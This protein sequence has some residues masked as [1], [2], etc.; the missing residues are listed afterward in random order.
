MAAHQ[1]S[2]RSSSARPSSTRLL[3]ACLAVSP[4]LIALTPAVAFA[5]DSQQAVSVDV[6][7][8]KYNFIGEIDGNNV[9]VRSGPADSHYPVAKL[10]RGTRVKVVGIRGNYLKIEPPDGTF[11][12]VGKAYVER[13]GD[14]TQGKVNTT[15]NVRAGSDINA[16][17]TY[18]QTKLEPGMDVKIQGEQDEYYKIDPPAGA[19]VYIHEQYVRPVQV[20]GDN[21]A[22]AQP[23]Q[24]RPQ[25]PGVATAPQPQQDRNPGQPPVEAAQGGVADRGAVEQPALPD[26][27]PSTQ[28]DTAPSARAGTEVDGKF[29]Q[30]EAQFEA[31]AEKPVIEQPL[32]ELLAGYSTLSKEGDLPESLKRV[33]DARLAAIKV[34]QEAREQFRQALRSQGEMRERTQALQAERE[35][36]EQRLKESQVE[37]YTAV[38]TLRPSSLQQGPRGT[39]LYR[40]TDPATGR[41]LV[42]VRAKDNTITTSLNQFVGVRGEMTNDPQ[43]R[44]R[45]ITPTETKPVDQAKVGSGVA[46]AVI[47]PSILPKIQAPSP[48]AG[49]SDSTA[50]IDGE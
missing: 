9:F 6:P 43:L 17:K 18:V 24:P 38:G 28:P 49:G 36:L 12:Y 1:R 37:F 25:D 4:A 46:A 29:E 45:V 10:G 35:E 23:E 20:L 27:G 47:P 48:S 34:R 2:P 32:D 16:M 8:A 42:Y 5:Q 22:L 31:A 14:G 40:L 44:L 33:A 15:A 21:V 30:L 19:Y 41:T 3:A 11:S 50:P 13:H 39:T 7:N 26:A